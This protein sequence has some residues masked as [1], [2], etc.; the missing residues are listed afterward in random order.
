M[1]LLDAANGKEIRTFSLVKSEWACPHLAVVVAF[2]PDGSAGLSALRSFN[3]GR[4]L[5]YS[6]GIT[7]WDLSSGN[8]LRDFLRGRGPKI[9]NN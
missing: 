2:S 6:G 5:I 3:T 7:L 4:G 9:T 8:E 1:V